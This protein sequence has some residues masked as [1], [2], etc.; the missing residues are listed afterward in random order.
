MAL[1][2]ILRMGMDICSALDSCEKCSILHRDIKTSNIYYSERAGYKLG[3][4]GISRTMDSIHERLSL[5][6]AGTIQYMAPE[7]YLG[8]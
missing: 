4:F 1:G 5:T 7:I 3:D 6:S 2:E 8:K